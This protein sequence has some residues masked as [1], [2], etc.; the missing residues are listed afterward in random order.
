[1][2]AVKGITP[3][4]VTAANTGLHSDQDPYSLMCTLAF[5]QC[6]AVSQLSPSCST[7][8]LAAAMMQSYSP[9][10]IGRT[11]RIPSIP[12]LSAT[13]LQWSN[14]ARRPCVHIY[15]CFADVLART[16]EMPF[17]SILLNQNQ[18]KPFKVTKAHVNNTF[19]PGLFPLP[20]RTQMS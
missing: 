13:P 6:N 17:V 8:K 19:T 14:S 11:S 2:A 9:N 15:S 18:F 4:Q 7:P 5:S 20:S 10:A 1:M 3:A 16:R 12:S